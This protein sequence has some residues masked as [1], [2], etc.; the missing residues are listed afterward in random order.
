MA[1]AIVSI[2]A[3]AFAVLAALELANV[4]SDRLGLGIGTTL[5][6]VAIAVGLLWAGTRV[7]I[8]EAWARSPLV[9]AQLILLGLAWNFRGDAA[10]VTPSIAAPA[11][12][13]LA[14]LLAPP[15]TRALGRGPTV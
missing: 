4:S 1:A 13:V 10:W 14:C 11:L 3:V 12:V 7:V 8:G 15:V 5:F 6:M 9:F 2:E